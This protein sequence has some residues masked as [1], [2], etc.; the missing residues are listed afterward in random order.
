MQFGGVLPE[1]APC[2][3]AY[4]LIGLNGQVGVVSPQGIRTC[5]FGCIVGVGKKRRTKIGLYGDT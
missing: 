3:A 1:A 5:S 4:A 2:C